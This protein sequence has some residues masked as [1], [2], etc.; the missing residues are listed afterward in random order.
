MIVL[1]ASAACEALINEG[2]RAALVRE[3]LGDADA[4]ELHVPELFALEVTSAVRGHLRAGALTRP[5]AK[6]VLADLLALPDVHWRHGDLV[7]R[8]WELRDN[9]TPYDA[10][11]AALAEVLGA[12]L[13][14]TDAALGGVRRLRCTVNVI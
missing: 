7:E 2:P 3:R 11:Y 6:E 5:G 4:G 9:L 13:L 10:A 12:T 8:V 1:D 14:T